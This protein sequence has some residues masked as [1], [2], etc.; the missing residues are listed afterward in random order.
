MNIIPISD[1]II[2]SYGDGKNGDASENPAQHRQILYAEAKRVYLA[3][4][5]F[6]GRHGYMNKKERQ[7]Q[8]LKKGKRKKIIAVGVCVLV[9]L[10]LVAL[11]AV[12]AYQQGRNR[13]YTDGYQTL[14]LRSDGSF[15]AALS[16]EVKAGTYVENT[17]D[18]VIT[19]TFISEGTSVVG[20]IE[21]EVLTLPDEWDDGHGHGTTLMLK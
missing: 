11:L 21:N 5:S 12:N 9:V 17:E 19:V 8:A 7:A 18:G 15:T 20:G 3:F 16:H 1:T 14:M 2:S 4:A 6:A 10:V 13:T